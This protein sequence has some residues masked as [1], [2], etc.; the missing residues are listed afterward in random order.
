ME[1]KEISYDK[2]II[3]SCGGYSGIYLISARLVCSGSR[4]VRDMARC[5][6]VAARGEGVIFRLETLGQL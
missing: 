1:V 3:V 6:G 2:T 4:F 5:V